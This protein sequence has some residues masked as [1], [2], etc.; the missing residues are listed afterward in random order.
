MDRNRYGLIGD[1]SVKDYAVECWRKLSV[2]FIGDM[3][4]VYIGTLQAVGSG[5]N[6]LV[7]AFA[8]GI[9]IGLLIMGMGHISGGHFN[10]AVTLGVLVSG[11]IQIITAV[12]YMICQL[13]GGFVGSVLARATVDTSVWNAILGGTVPPSAVSVSTPLVPAVALFSAPQGILLEAIMTY[14]LVNSVLMSAVDTDSNILA[15]FCIGLSIFVDILAGGAITGA[16]M[17]PAR[18]LGPAIAA[19]IWPVPYMN[20]WAW[21]YVY[22][23]GPGLGALVAGVV[24]KSIFARDG[25]RWF[26]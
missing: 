16:S 20:A 11:N 12:L 26:L 25:Q 21:H 23:V 15:P 14:V 10:P 8:H 9:T 18:S 2:E 24:Y 5:G 3:I 17:N 6:I 7:P 19:T 22:W 13:L 4:F 1:R